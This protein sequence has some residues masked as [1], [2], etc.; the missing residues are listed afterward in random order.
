MY[1]KIA[2]NTFSQ[3]F[4]KVGTALISIFLLS[5]LTNYLSVEMFWMYSKIYNYVWIFVFLADL[6]LYTIAIREIANNKKDSEKIVWN[7][8]TLRTILW[9]V[10]F[11]FAIWIAYFLDGYN[12]QLAILWITIACFFTMFQLW[13]SSILTLMQAHMKMEFSLVS[14]ILWK[15]ANFLCI[16]WIVF[17]IFPDIT[18]G[19]YFYPFLLIMLSWLLGTICMTTLNFL[20]AKKIWKIRFLFDRQYIWKIFKMSLP[21]WIALFLSVVYFKVDIILLSILEPK[22]VADR[23]VAL[24]SLPMKIVEVIMVIGGF[25]LNAMLPKI[26]Q[27]FKNKNLISANKLINFSFKIMYAGSLLMATLWILFREHIIAI[28]SKPEYLDSSLAFHSWDAAI[29]VFWVILF[30][31]LSLVFIY[32]LIASNQQS[33]LLKINLIVTL[34]NIVWNIILIPYLSFMWAWLV[35]IISQI[36]LMILGYYYTKSTVSISIT[37]SFLLRH[38]IFAVVVFHLWVLIM[39]KYPLWHI[40]SI[41]IYGVWLFMCYIWFFYFEFKDV[42]IKLRKKT[43]A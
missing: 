23:S 20:Y 3:I 32:S 34:V 12:S 21:Y 13:N 43:E 38:F 35:T 24:Y 9:I 33:K 42:I 29:V 39:D 37:P 14:T 27:D 31:F 19:N 1:K 25:Y 28:I 17:L 41:L 18:D 22:E 11:I 10:I 5:V 26:S 36:V 2:S 8:L 40:L 30:H 4:S 7:V 15:L 6:G 16:L